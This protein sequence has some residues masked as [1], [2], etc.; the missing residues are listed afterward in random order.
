LILTKEPVYTDWGV[1]VRWR[2]TKRSQDNCTIRNRDGEQ[3][4]KFIKRGRC[5]V[6]AWAPS[7]NPAADWAGLN[8]R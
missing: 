6:V 3:C 4:V 2:V 8:F 1:T 7:L 5:T